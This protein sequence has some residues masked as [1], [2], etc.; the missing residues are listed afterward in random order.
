MGESP[1]QYIIQYEGLQEECRGS[2]K[3]FSSY[4]CLHFCLFLVRGQSI[5]LLIVSVPS[6]LTFCIMAQYFEES[7]NFETAFG[8]TYE[9]RG[10]Q[11][12]DNPLYSSVLQKFGSNP[13]IVIETVQLI[14]LYYNDNAAV[15]Y[16][17]S[18][19]I[20]DTNPYQYLKFEYIKHFI[21]NPCLPM[22]FIRFLLDT[23]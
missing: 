9:R 5:S 20:G 14:S 19:T 6:P 11:E 15:N 8:G 13:V 3:I 16:L 23:V 18:Q 17:P 1:G 21:F 4:S 2:A 22:S 10:Q 7:L 12:K